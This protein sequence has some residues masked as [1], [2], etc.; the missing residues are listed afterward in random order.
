MHPLRV[1]YD[2]RD[3]Q[4]LAVCNSVDMDSAISSVAVPLIMLLSGNDE[5]EYATLVADCR[6]G[7]IWRERRRQ[8]RGAR[9]SLG[10]AT[11][12]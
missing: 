6:A 5:A 7:R 4:T 3:R 1:R 8:C 9:R 2:G 12:R 11:A 10:S